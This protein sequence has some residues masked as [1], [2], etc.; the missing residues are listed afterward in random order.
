[1]I[2]EK[3]YMELNIGDIVENKG[4]PDLFIIIFKGKT[5][6]DRE[7]ITLFNLHS[8]TF[9]SSFKED[10]K[11]NFF[12]VDKKKEIDPANPANE[13]INSLIFNFIKLHK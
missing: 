4:N 13:I 9:A 1:M 6:S 12:K 8:S 11:N 2:S 7:M 3:E 10:F 5:Y